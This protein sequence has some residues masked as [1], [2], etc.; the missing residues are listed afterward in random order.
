MYK[1]NGK[2]CLFAYVMSALLYMIPN[3]AW[4][5]MYSCMFQKLLRWSLI[6]D[7][8]KIHHILYVNC[9]PSHF[10]SLMVAGYSALSVRVCF[11]H[12]YE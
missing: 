3:G 10:L 4:T 11:A 6:L 5:I 8:Y 12:H 7:L 9:I 2:Y 1:Q